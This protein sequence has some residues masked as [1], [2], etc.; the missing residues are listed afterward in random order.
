VTGPLDEE[1]TD[2]VRK[3][4][5]AVSDEIEQHI[6]TAKDF[7]FSSWVLAKD[8]KGSTELMELH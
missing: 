5:C 4:A 8:D 2:L 3:A 7:H 1:S 6:K